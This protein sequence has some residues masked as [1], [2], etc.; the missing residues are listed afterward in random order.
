MECIKYP[1]I[2]QFRNVVKDMHH[3]YSSQQMPVVTFTGTVK[4]H[5]TNASVVFEGQE[6]RPQSRN[7]TLTVGNDN[8]GFALWHSERIELFSEL[9][10]RIDEPDIGTIVIYGE[11]A[12]KG[13]QKGVAVSEAEKFFYVIGVKVVSSSGGESWLDE[14]QSMSLGI[15]I[16]DAR[17][18][19]RKSID[20]DFSNPQSSQNRLAGETLLIE[21]QCPVGSFLGKKGLGEGAVWSCVTAQGEML[22]FKVKGEKHSVSKV[23]TLA[24]VAPEKIKSIEHFVSYSV[25]ENRLDQGFTEVCGGIADRKKL[26]DFLGW[27]GRDI[28]KEEADVLS[29]NGLT[30]KEVGKF[31]SLK[32]RNWFFSKE[33]CL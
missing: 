21:E 20:I 15:D 31:I 28:H 11:F 23:K 14:Y 18:V 3:L 7:N 19:W 1:K 22:A 2:G 4:V 25:T 26:G 9:R 12:G 24:S 10:K 5:G 16:I 30:M 8:A 17:D 27:I 13:I 6:Q 33:S 29:K 32:A